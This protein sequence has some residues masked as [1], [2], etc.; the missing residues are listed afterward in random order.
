M[1]APRNSRPIT[2]ALVDDYDVV[3]IGLAHLF[4][5]Y[6][7]RVEVVELDANVKVST[8]VDVVLYDS[9][10]QAEASDAD[11]GTLVR[12]PLAGRVAVYT[13]TFAPELIEKAL[14]KGAAG[15]LSKTLPAR[16]LVESIEAIHRGETV[17]SPAPPRRIATALD[18]PGRAERLSERESEI[19][20][21]I[22]QGRSN[23]EIAEIAYLSINSV[24]T[25]IRSAYRKI[26]VF[27]RVE[28]VL[29]GVDHG[30]TPDHQRLR[31]WGD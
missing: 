6:E 26:G 30:F 8:Y 7:R 27:N 2:L 17:V 29:W 10:A 14:A 19:L 11:L 24:K 4:K 23:A 20:A 28:A 16:E 22:T 13:W 1:S 21:L 18:W 12:N 5:A 3:L 31:N 15:Y 9:F 25:Y